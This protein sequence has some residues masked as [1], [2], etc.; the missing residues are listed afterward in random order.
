MSLG[1]LQVATYNVH[2]CI[3]RGRRRNVDRVIRVLQ[4]LEA[5]VIALQEVETLI[6]RGAEHDQ[7]VFIGHSLAMRSIPGPT[8][9]RADSTY[10][11]VLL[12]VHRVLQVRRHDL[13][14]PGREFRGALDVDLD[15]EG[16]FV[17]V[18]TTHLGLRRR[19]RDLQIRRLLQLLGHEPRPTVLLGDFNEWWPASPRLRRLAALGPVWAPPGFPAWLPLVALDRIIPGP[20]L[21]VERIEAVRSGEAAAASDH[22]PVRAALRF[23]T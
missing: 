19:E 10:G 3:G 5:T 1:T 21:A 12:T 13:S 16:R 22:L 15:V 9:L 11:N 4:R 2:R 6:G 7:F 20:G 17:R 14:V 23:C 18:L 8:M